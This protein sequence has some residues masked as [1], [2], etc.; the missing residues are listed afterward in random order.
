MAG[1]NG[2]GK[3]TLYKT[4]KNKF[5]TGVWINADDILSIFNQKGFIELSY[6]KFIPTALSFSEFVQLKSSSAFIQEFNLYNE[7]DNL[8][9][10]DYS[11]AFHSKNMSNQFA[12]FFTDFLRH[13]LLKANISFT[14]ETVFSHQSKL[15]LAKNAKANNYKTYLYFIA[16]VSPEINI[17]RI[18][19][20]VAKGG[21]FVTDEKVRTRYKNSIS[22][23]S[24]NIHLFDRVFIFDNST[25]S[26]TLIASFHLGKLDKFY[27]P[28]LPEWFKNIL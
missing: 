1:P 6:F 15:Q 8:K 2:S 28:E 22:L 20:R 27:V 14:T 7:I 3:S 25:D 18:N 9:F 24:K 17:R 12:A 26:I 19:T 11:V 10:G 23:I 16:T 4:I 5:D 21:H 13:S